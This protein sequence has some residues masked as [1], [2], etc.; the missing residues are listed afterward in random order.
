MYSAT[1]LPDS[2][3]HLIT[4]LSFCPIYQQLQ[5]ASLYTTILSD[6]FARIFI[7]D[8]SG[9]GFVQNRTLLRPNVERE[10]FCECEVEKFAL[11]ESV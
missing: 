6:T 5:P 9:S 8:Q 2:R 7:S 1:R 10:T 4:C 3:T 11:R